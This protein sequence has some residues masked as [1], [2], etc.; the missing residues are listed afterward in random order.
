MQLPGRW[1]ACAYTEG[2]HIRTWRALQSSIGRRDPSLLT[3]SAVRPRTPPRHLM[4]KPTDVLIVGAGPV[5]LTAALLLG[6]KDVSVHVLEAQEA[7]A[8][9][10]RASTFHSPTLDLMAPY[11]ITDRMLQAGLVGTNLADPAAPVGRARAVRAQGCSRARPITPSGCNC[12]QS[13]LLRLASLDAVRELPNVDVS[14][15]RPQ[16]KGVEQS[17][18]GVTVKASSPDGERT[19]SAGW[20]IGAD[21]VRSAVRG[22]QASHL[23]ATPIQRPRSSRPLPFHSKTI[24]PACPT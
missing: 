16:A 12:E 5:G 10:L 11:G 7:L 2:V 18:S 19:F 15:R 6:R 3:P 14:C 1:S 17:G 21:G 13:K 4:S 20:V 22:R 9:D 8:Q 23:K 24:S